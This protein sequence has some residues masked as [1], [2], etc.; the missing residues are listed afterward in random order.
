MLDAY[1][2]ERIQR[3]R[4]REQARHRRVPLRIERPPPSRP[5]ERPEPDKP[6]ERG[7]AVIDFHL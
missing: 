7:S 5:D 1:I 3:E 6:D 2:I 4:A